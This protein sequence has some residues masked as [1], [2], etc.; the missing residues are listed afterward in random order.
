MFDSSAFAQGLALGL[1][2]FVCPGPK[3][4]VIL[5]QA[6]LRRPTAE[7]LAAGVGSDALLILVGM[8]G[9]SAALREAPQLQQAAMWAGVALLVWHGA[10]ASWR[11]V[12]GPA[13]Q[14][15]PS[16]VG[17][18]DGRPALLLASFVNPLAWLDTVLVIGTAGALL[19]SA[20]Q[21]SY[22]GGAVT[23]S[24]AWFASLIFGARNAAR[25][26]TQPRSWQV[27]DAFAAAAMIGLATYIGSGLV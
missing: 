5:R 15:A 3:D 27:L 13:Q 8:A 16:V 22:V 24:A 4:L 21:A 23:A 1:G 12:A 7:L 17:G 19:P 9:V 20:A 25:W 14:A 18:L 11:A 6:L 10:L 2:M 26:M